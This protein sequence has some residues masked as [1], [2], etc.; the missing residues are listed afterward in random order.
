MATINN[1]NGHNARRAAP[2]GT[3]VVVHLCIPEHQVRHLPKRRKAPQRLPAAAPLPRVG[4]V[5][6]LSRSSAWG[7]AL[8]VHEWE[9]PDR[10]RVEVW[11]EHVDSPRHQRP[12]GFS[13]TQ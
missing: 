2:N 6:Y 12:T 13:L 11:L 3:D 8:V 7:V 9:A 4:E 10:L 5:V 1:N